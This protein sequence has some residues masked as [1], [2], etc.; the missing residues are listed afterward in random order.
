MAGP[1]TIVTVCSAA[2][3]APP[4]AR[5][6][7]GLGVLRAPCVLAWVCWAFKSRRTPC[8]LRLPPPL[9]ELA[10]LGGLAALPFVPA[11]LVAMWVVSSSSLSSSS[12]V[13]PSRASGTPQSHSFPRGMAAKGAA[14][15]H[16]PPSAAPRRQGMKSGRVR[17]GGTDGG[18]ADRLDHAPSLAH[19]HPRTPDLDPDLAVV[20]R[21]SRAG[22]PLSASWRQ[23]DKPQPSPL[24]TPETKRRRTLVSKMSTTDTMDG[25]PAIA[26]VVAGAVI[27]AER[28][29]LFP[30]AD[31]RA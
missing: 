18:V 7:A 28:R 27:Y 8:P 15:G 4:A 16:G 10:V 22:A 1:A 14:E 5:F 9:D 17:T 25:E 13:Q 6:G 31:R 21:M 23:V 29:R 12:S 19:P 26:V 20:V 2:L 11:F 24:C 3:V 30:T